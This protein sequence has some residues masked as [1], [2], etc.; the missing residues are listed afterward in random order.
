MKNAHL[1][2]IS[3]LLLSGCASKVHY[4]LNLQ[5][6]E[7]S[8]TEKQVKW[9]EKEFE[10]AYKRL[11]ECKNNDIQRLMSIRENGSLLAPH[12]KKYFDFKYATIKAATEEML[13][14]Y[15]VEDPYRTLCA[16]V[17]GYDSNTIHINTQDNMAHFW[18]GN[19]CFDLWDTLGHEMLHLLGYRHSTEEQFVEMNRVLYECGFPQMNYQQYKQ[20]WEKK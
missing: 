16:Y 8:F 7:G 6:E 11:K 20:Q 9:I 18:R 14:K 1:L 15:Y 5:F 19:A 3:L 4:P 13:A 2:C 12:Y 17:M 10:Y